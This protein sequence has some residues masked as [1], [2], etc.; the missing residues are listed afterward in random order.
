MMAMRYKKKAKTKPLP[1]YERQVHWFS[2]KTRTPSRSIVAILPSFVHRGVS[3]VFRVDTPSADQH[4]VQTSF[5]NCFILRSQS[6]SR[7]SVAL[8][9]AR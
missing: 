2:I 8:R 1:T 4:P 9:A 5:V 7:A 3:S 6:R